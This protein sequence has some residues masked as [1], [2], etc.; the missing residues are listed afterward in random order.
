MLKQYYTHNLAEQVDNEGMS[1]DTIKEK[2]ID[3]Y[4]SQ[5]KT[6]S[7]FKR[8]SNTRR[9]DIQATLDELEI[10]LL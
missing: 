2:L 9:E 4:K 3:F 5:G 8:T 7:N 10:P 6:I 1:L